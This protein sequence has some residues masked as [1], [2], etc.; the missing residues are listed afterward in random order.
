TSP[1]IPTGPP[2]CGSRWRATTGPTATSTSGPIPD[3]SSC[4][5]PPTAAGWPWPGWPERRCSWWPAG[6]ACEALGHRA[7]ASRNRSNR[8]RK[9]R[10]SSEYP[11]IASYGLIGDCHS[12]ALVSLSGSIDWCCL[13]RFDSGSCFGRLL[14][15]RKGGYCSITPT[16]RSYSVSRRYVDDTLVLETTFRARGGEARV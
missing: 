3:L 9:A 11:P 16:A 8:T 10:P 5:R 15:W 4:G 12:A 2:T 7:V 14:D 1:P 13:P 6:G